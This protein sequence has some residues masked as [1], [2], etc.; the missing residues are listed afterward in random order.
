MTADDRNLLEWER[1]AWWFC[2]PDVKLSAELQ[3]RR[4]ELDRLLES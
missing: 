3:A 2:D 4:E 1:A